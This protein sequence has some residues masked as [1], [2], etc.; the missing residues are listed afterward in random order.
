MG[1]TSVILL[2]GISVFFDNII[3]FFSGIPE[4][5]SNFWSF[6]SDFLIHIFVPEDDYFDNTI[7]DIKS[8]FR[9]KIPYEDFMKLFEDVKDVE[10]SSSGL[11]VNFSGYKIGDKTIETGNNW[12]RFDFV[13]KHKDTWFAWCR[14][15]T[16]IFFIIYNINQFLKFLGRLGVVEG[17]NLS[18]NNS[19]KGES[20]Q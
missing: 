16:Y 4:F 3:Q 5:F 17:S 18:V 12:V 15:F 14:G 11:N 1:V 2:I 20:K 8:C 7:N 10:G 9:D 6:F 19:V 13:L